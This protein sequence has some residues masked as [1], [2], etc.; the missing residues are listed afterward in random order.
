MVIG[1]SLIVLQVSYSYHVGQ[2][3]YLRIY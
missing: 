1:I 3:E 2:T